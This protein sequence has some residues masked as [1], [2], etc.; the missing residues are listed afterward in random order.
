[1]AIDDIQVGQRVQRNGTEWEVM[2]IK[3]ANG[4]PHAQ[5][6]KVG[7]PTEHLPDPGRVAALRLVQTP[8]RHPSRVPAQYIERLP[9][10]GGATLDKPLSR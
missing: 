6:L 5:I 1:M 8:L 10:R 9:R 3:P 4:L 2:D 7:D